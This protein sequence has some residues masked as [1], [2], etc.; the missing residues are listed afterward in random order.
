M[1]SDLYAARYTDPLMHTSLFA[2]II[3]GIGEALVYVAIG[4]LAVAAVVAIVATGGAGAIVLGCVAKALIGAAA[5]AFAGAAFGDQI[6]SAVSSVANLVPKNPDAVIIT[7]SLNT[8]TNGLFSA[9]AAGSI[10]TEDILGT[11]DQLRHSEKYKDDNQ[12]DDGSNEQLNLDRAEKH[13]DLGKSEESEQDESFFSKVTNVVGDFL[14]PVETA[15]HPAAVPKDGDQV[16]C[17]K[18]PHS[19]NHLAQGSMTVLINSQPAAR[20]GDK[21]V[22]GAEIEPKGKC[23]VWIGG[24]TATVRDVH[25]GVS[26]I[27]KIL[28]VVSTIYGLARMRGWS[29]F[30]CAALQYGASYLG[31][32]IGEGIGQRIGNP[33]FVPTGAKVLDGYDEL[34]FVL[35]GPLDYQWQRTYNSSNFSVGALG[36]GWQLPFEL[37]LSIEQNDGEQKLVFASYMGR[38]IEFDY[39]PEG[40]G[41]YIVNEGFYIYHFENHRWLIEYVDG[42]AFLFEPIA[43]GS[44]TVHLTQISDQNFNHYQLVYNEYQQLI[45]MHDHHKDRILHLTYDNSRLSKVVEERKQ[46]Q[47]TLVSYHYNERKELIKVMR[48]DVLM[49]QFSYNDDGLMIMHEDVNHLQSHYR[50]QYHDDAPIEETHWRVAKHWLTNEKGDVLEEYQLQYDLSERSLT[51]DQKG[52][53][54]SFHQWNKAELITRYEDVEGNIWQQ[55]WDDDRNLISLIDPLGNETTFTY[56]ENGNRIQTKNA[57]G[58]S[59]FFKWHK[60]FA[61]PLLAVDTEG[62]ATRYHYDDHGNLIKEINANGGMTL[63]QYNDLGQITHIEDANQ[64]LTRYFY[65][66]AGDLIEV[67]DCSNY[68][69][70]I[71]YNL[72]GDVVSITDATGAKTEYQYNQYS[73]L[74][75]IIRPDG[76][77]QSYGYDASLRIS[78]VI[79][80]GGQHH[81]YEYDCRG[82]LLTHQN[83]AGKTLNFEYDA[84]GRLLTLYNENRE[85]YH[86]KYDAL[87][88]LVSQRDL[89]GTETHYQYDGLGQMLMVSQYANS[90][91]E[92]AYS[93]IIQR[94]EYDAIGRMLTKQSFD[95][96]TQYDYPKAGFIVEDH[97]KNGDLKTLNFGFDP[98]GQLIEENNPWGKISHQYDPVGNLLAT[99]MPDGRSIEHL[100]YGSG[101]LHQ[102]SLFNGK[103]HKIIADFERDELHREIVRSHGKI[104]HQKQ[105]DVVGR[106]KQQSIRDQQI[107]DVFAPIIQQRFSYDHADHLTQR[108]MIL[109]DLSTPQRTQSQQ[110]QTLHYDQLGQIVAD[111]NSI[112]KRT[113]ETFHYDPAGNLLPEKLFKTDLFV[114][115]N[116]TTEYGTMLYSYDG[117]GRM[118]TREGHQGF[119]KQRFHYDSESRITKIELLNHGHLKSVEFEYDPL[120]RRTQKRAIPK[121]DFHQTETTSFGWVGMQ[122]V[123][124]H[125]DKTKNNCLYIYNDGS[126]EPLAR[127][128]KYDDDDAIAEKISYYSNHI[129]GCPDAMLDDDGN[130]VWIAKITTFGKAEKELKVDRIVVQQNLRYQGQYLD[131]ETGLHYNTFRYYDPEIG[132]FT[133]QDP[134]GLAGGFNL[135][136]YA[137][138]MIHWIDP[139][140]WARCR[141]DKGRF[142]STSKNPIRYNRK[143]EYPSSYRA[144]VREAVLDANTIQRGRN[145]GKVRMAD[146]KIVDRNDP[147]IT[148]EHN[149]SVVDHWNTVGHNSTR[150]VRNDFYNNTDNMSLLL[151][152]D[153]SHGGGIMSSQGI[154]YK[155]ETGSGYSR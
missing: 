93:P 135:Y 115:H 91:S 102:T 129:N 65:N 56:D 15:A 113:E 14:N 88:R 83:P 125:N 133:Q 36:Q 128:E 82:A 90:E 31:G 119:E 37:G 89:V 23:N 53:G 68:P 71:Q 28:G 123:H 104:S 137:P 66:E 20:Q 59:E 154:T 153:N 17:Q 38:N 141:D 58:E 12:S 85:S 49:R 46:Q 57:L 1:G 106:L 103:D 29:K 45:M 117:F 24:E 26:P 122:M 95:K 143:S 52:I 27:G 155:Q 116:Q 150:A 30:A 97:L 78:N 94:F 51:V 79:D 105:Y 2:D 3:S 6:S 34:D 127:L 13:K 60:H 22:C 120:G 96:T 19:P 62:N 144:G 42:D 25:S 152:S 86:F 18:W 8:R 4:A 124:E 40:E 111:Y 10:A 138:N 61:L 139:W 75:Q 140:G 142:V 98:L 76:Q 74:T 67:R 43:E 134:I 35:Q 55:T 99:K 147:R 92:L 54:E 39:I 44:E 132:R 101:H 107:A 87:H 21:S 126:Y 48:D 63:Y 112:G 47:R 114:K 11:L 108:T 80:F 73:L 145:K 7:G 81:R 146:G 149:Q 100:Y 69:T 33:I 77:Q 50:W 121:E 70:K 136:Q 130:I 41:A 5:G 110:E 151:R 109:G 84:L 64:K 118:L 131:R 72:W 16:T 148:I 9:R 32:K